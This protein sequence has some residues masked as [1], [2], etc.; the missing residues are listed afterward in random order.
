MAPAPSTSWSHSTAR[1]TP[2]SAT[3]CA[4]SPEFRHRIS[5]CAPASAR[6]GTRRG[7][8]SRSC[9]SSGWPPGSCPATWFSWH[10]TSKRSTG[11]RGP[12]P[13]SPTC[14]RGPRHTSRVPAG[15][16]WTRR[17]GCWPARAT[18]R[19]RLR[20]TPP[21]RHP[22]A[23]APTCATPCW[24]SPT[25]SPAYTKT[26]VSRCPTPTSPGRPSVRWASASMSGWPPPTSG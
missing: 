5:R 15:S 18:F 7:C 24:S 9:V 21:A 1:S 6:A 3:A 14:T 22:S 20:P 25:P 12:P 10:P 23:A 4:W 16:G 26:H 17:R 13:T 2:T 19:W 11:R 8:W